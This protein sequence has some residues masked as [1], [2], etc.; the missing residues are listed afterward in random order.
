[1]SIINMLAQQTA[2]EEARNSTEVFRAAASRMDI[3]HHPDELLDALARMPFIAASVL[4][5]LGLLCVFNGYRWHKWVVVILAFLAGVGLGNML[6]DHFGRSNIVAVAIG[7]LCA[8][9]ATPM[10]KVTVAIFAG[11]T[12]AFIGANIWTAFNASAAGLNWAGAAMGFILL[13][14]ASLMMF[15]LV[16]VLFTSVGGA[17]MVVFG[18]ITLLLHVENWEPAVRNSLVTNQLIVPVLVLLA[19][20]GGFVLQEGRSRQAESE[21]E[22]G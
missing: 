13:A 21:A 1:M 16:I 8:I 7:G 11:V 22:A 4:V 20:V 6:N 15:R 2:G 14:L 9:A 5:I 17:A 18:V 3:L 10:L 12:G 19:A